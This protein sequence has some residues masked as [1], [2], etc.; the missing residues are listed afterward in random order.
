MA[1]EAAAVGGFVNACCRVSITFGVLV[2]SLDR[3]T[4]DAD[5]SAGD[6]S[7]MLAAGVACLASGYATMAPG[8]T[9]SHTDTV[10]AATTARQTGDA[11]RT[12]ADPPHAQFMG[13]TKE[14]DPGAE[15]LQQL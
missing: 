9:T 13:S 6:R 12:M 4:F 15:D 8:R 10:N 11:R 5:S 1:P 14:Y 2:G 7:L 3:V